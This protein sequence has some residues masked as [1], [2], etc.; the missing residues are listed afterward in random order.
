MA[1][2]DDAKSSRVLDFLQQARRQTARSTPTP[3]TVEVPIAT[4]IAIYEQMRI[5]DELLMQVCDIG[6]SGAA[7]A[8]ADELRSTR[9]WAE[10]DLNGRDPAIIE[11]LRARLPRGN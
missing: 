5:Y 3:A 7:G 10:R 8:R 1:H 2:R 6:L 11:Q 4:L 9:A